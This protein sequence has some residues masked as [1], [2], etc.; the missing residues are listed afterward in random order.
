MKCPFCGAPESDY[1]GF[2]ECHTVSQ[3]GVALEHMRG[4]PCVQSERDN[5]RI[6]LMRLAAH[7]KRLEDTGDPLCAAGAF[8]GWHD[9]VEAWNKAREQ[10]P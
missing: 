2:Y 8:M 5:L 1:H 9:K 4:V 3:E 10:R 7:I 6:R